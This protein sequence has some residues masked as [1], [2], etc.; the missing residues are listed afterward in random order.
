MA[1]FFGLFNYDKEGPGIPKNAPPKRTIVVFFETLFR[2]F[3]KLMPVS[4]LYTLL[5][6]PLVTSGLAA[7]GIT[8]V[9]RNTAR[10][11]HS[12]GVSDFFST[13]KKNWRQALPAGIINS[14]LY[15]I[16]FFDVYFFFKGQDTLSSAGF[17]LVL[18]MLFVFTVM[19]FYMWT[20][21]ITFKFSLKQ[22]YK[23]SFKF[24]F[25]N[26]KNNLICLLAEAAVLAVYVGILLLFLSQFALVLT[27]EMFA[28]IFTFPTFKFLVEQYCVFPAIKKHIIDPYY[29]EHPDEDIEKRRDLGLDIPSDDEDEEETEEQNGEDEEQSLSDGD[30]D[31]A[32]DS[33]EP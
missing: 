2:N 3:W 6:L 9:A 18:A 33:V 32:S 7:A 10:D 24:V 21:M 13:I 17:G 12:F 30:D 19:N 25:I 4:A 15:A 1:G 20:L 26:M 8:H 22:I 11:R 27:I 31:T 23:N 29:D 28:F 16:L 5:S 14:I